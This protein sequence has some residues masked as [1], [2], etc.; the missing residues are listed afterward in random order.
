MIQIN[1][2]A[3][4]IEYIHDHEPTPELLTEIVRQAFKT[5]WIDCPNDVEK[6]V[7]I[8]TEFWEKWQGK[9]KPI[10]IGID[11][12]LKTDEDEN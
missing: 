8:L 1:T 10:F 12:S 6:Q 4:L 7:E 2:F 5:L 11:I 9:E 3:E